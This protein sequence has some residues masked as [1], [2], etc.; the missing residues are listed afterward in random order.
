MV[1]STS[2]L[3]PLY[4]Y[5]LEDS[6]PSIW[7]PLINAFGVCFAGTDCRIECYPTVH[8][9]VVINPNSGPDGRPDLPDAQYQRAIPY[10]QGYTNVTLIG[11]VS[12]LYGRRLLPEAKNDVDIYWRWHD[13]SR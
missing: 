8:F 7:D 11:Y 6:I 5:P 2:I 10:L 4:I 9:I 1:S 3:V 13:V 12:T